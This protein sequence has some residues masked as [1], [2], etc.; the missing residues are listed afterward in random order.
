MKMNIE[1]ALTEIKGKKVNG[2]VCVVKWLVT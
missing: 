2:V 1:Q